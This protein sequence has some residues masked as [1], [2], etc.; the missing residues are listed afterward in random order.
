[1]SYE[2]YEFIT[3]F[4]N[5]LMLD[6]QYLV[7]IVA[8]YSPSLLQMDMCHIPLQ[9]LRNDVQPSHYDIVYAS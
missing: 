7:T 1:M 6:E 4:G 5:V 3:L 9:D 8:Y 2:T